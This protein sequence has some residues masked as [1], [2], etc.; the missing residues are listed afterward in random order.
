VD[1]SLGWN[2]VVRLDIDRDGS[3]QTNLAYA[4][5]AGLTKA[6]TSF[7]IR[8]DYAPANTSAVLKSEP[9]KSNASA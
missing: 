2:T 5:A 3:S 4:S 1:Y 9:E 7:H 8:H 6:S